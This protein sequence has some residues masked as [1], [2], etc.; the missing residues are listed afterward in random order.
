[1]FFAKNKLP[2]KGVR[3]GIANANRIG[4]RIYPGQADDDKKIANAMEYQA[5]SLLNIPLDEAVLDWQVV[6][7][8]VDPEGVTTK[9]VML[10]V[11]YRD[12]VDRYVDACRKAGI[13]LAGVDLEAFA[14]LR[15]LGAPTEP[16]DRGTV[17]VAIGFDRST[18]A[19][20][21]GRTCDFT[22]VL[23]WGGWSLNTKL[24]DAFNSSP[25]EVEAL[26]CAISLDGSVVP[27][28]VPTESITLAVDT[29]KRE[30]QSFARQLVESLQFYQNQPGSLAIGEIVITGG[31][32]QMPGIAEELQRLIGVQVRVGNPLARLKVAKRVASEPQAV[33]SLAVAIGLG[34][35]D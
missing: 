19:V 8:T 21:D 32:A 28:G 33:G 18:F 26:K 25:S 23:E 10:V 16:G 4:V 27:P 11:A 6:E 20:T 15:A 5:Q 3:L 12:L 14:M 17:A 34:I 9:K 35:E 2:K 24:A 7:E 29:V 22:R 30:L 13:T 31:T 1:L